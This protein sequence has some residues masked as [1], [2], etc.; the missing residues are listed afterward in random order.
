MTEENKNFV[1]KYSAGA[2]IFKQGEW[3]ASMFIIHSG[4]IRITRDIEGQTE[5]LGVLEKGDFFGEMSLLEDVPRTAAAIAEDDSEVIEIDKEGFTKLLKSNVEIPI[6]M[7]RKYALKLEEMNKKFEYLLQNKREYDKGIREIISQLKG[8]E[9]VSEPNPGEENI[10]AYLKSPNA[11][12]TFKITGDST[13][14][15]RIDPVTNIIPDVDLTKLDVGRTVSRRHARL[16]YVNKKLHLIEE[17][18]VTNGTFVNGN[19]LNSGELRELNEGDKLTF[20][21]VD[22]VFNFVK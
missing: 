20:G 14:I 17:I 6:R 22:L 8:K 13:L 19:Q 16:T 4:R 7:I 18:G 2:V 15:G 1:K 21:K 3:G 5:D 11:A 12:F 10:F 9:E